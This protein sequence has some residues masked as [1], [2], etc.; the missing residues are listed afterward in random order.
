MSHRARMVTTFL[1]QQGITKIEYPA[2]KRLQ[3]HHQSEP[4][5]WQ[6]FFILHPTQIEGLDID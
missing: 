1:Q 2:V 4:D 3:S 5:D 6:V